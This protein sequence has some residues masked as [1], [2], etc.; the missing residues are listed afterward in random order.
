[1]LVPNLKYTTYTQ[2]GVEFLR[3]QMFPRSHGLAAAYDRQVKKS[4]LTVPRST[5]KK[6]Y[7]KNTYINCIFLDRAL[8][9]T[10]IST[11]STSDFV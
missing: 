11:Y 7:N 9:S 6:I 4:G 1:M 5:V 10:K 3:I 8:F 2:A